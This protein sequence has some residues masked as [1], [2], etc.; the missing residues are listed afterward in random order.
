MSDQWV[1]ASDI[2]DYV[3]CRKAWWLQHVA[4]IEAQDSTQARMGSAYHRKHGR[5]VRR[6]RIGRRLA[7][8]CF[9]LAA[10]LLALSLASAL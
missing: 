6:G 1:R 9:L 5:D 10:G 2:G 3:Y 7:L 4:R 8:V